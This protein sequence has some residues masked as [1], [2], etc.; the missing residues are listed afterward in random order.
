M[1][2]WQPS[3][4]GLVL[5]KGLLC[6]ERASQLAAA[7]ACRKA[8][9]IDSFFFSCLYFFLPSSIYHFSIAR[10]RLLSLMTVNHELVWSSP[11]V[12][13][14]VQNKKKERIKN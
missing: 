13:I 5:F 7:C 10:R 3:P 2:G 11:V 8:I 4:P 14:D 6:L 1:D 9:L 12:T